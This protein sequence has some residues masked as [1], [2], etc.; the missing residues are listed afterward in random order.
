MY[1][2]VKSNKVYEI[3][4]KQTF[5]GKLANFYPIILHK[6]VQRS[7]LYKSF[8]DYLLKVELSPSKNF[9]YLLDLK[10]L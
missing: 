2:K 3:W 4:Q 6:T 1:E 7:I 10:A 9:C 5:L 8:W